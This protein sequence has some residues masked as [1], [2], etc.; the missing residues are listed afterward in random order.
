MTWENHKQW[1]RNTQGTWTNK[2]IQHSHRIQDQQAKMF[3]YTNNEHKK[4]DI[5]NIIPFIIPPKEMR[6]FNRKWDILIK[7]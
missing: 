3:L 5:K 1:Y 6:H 7:I 2:W 4:T